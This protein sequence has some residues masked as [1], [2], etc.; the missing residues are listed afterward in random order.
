[1]IEIKITCESLV[2]EHKKII[3]CFFC[4][5]WLIFFCRK[6]INGGIYWKHLSQL[7]FPG[8]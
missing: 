7:Y 2:S 5:F 6:E 3:N 4:S 8:I 1:M